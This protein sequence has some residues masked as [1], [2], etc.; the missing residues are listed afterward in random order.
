MFQTHFVGV[1]RTS[2]P[3]VPLERYSFAWFTIELIFFA[4]D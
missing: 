1:F 2:E 4:I 3:S